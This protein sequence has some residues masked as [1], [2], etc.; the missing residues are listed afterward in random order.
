[1]SYCCY[2]T[3][4]TG[5][6]MPMFYIGHTTVAKITKGYRGS[7]SS[8]D[9][10]KVWKEEL[11]NN[12]HLFKTEI[13]SLHETRDEALLQEE[14]YHKKFKVHK[15]SLYINKATACGSFYSEAKGKKNPMYGSKRFGAKNP[16]Y[17][18]SHSKETRNKMSLS[19]K[20]KHSQPKTEE[21]KS[22]MR[23]KYTGKS[24]EQRYGAEKS[25]E[26]KNILSAPKSQ[27]HKNKQS[28]S[29]KNKPK[30]T[31]QHCGKLSSAGNYAKW[32]G[33]K[34]KSLLQEA[35]HP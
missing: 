18:K 3:T 11:K 6:K 34:C 13:L 19:G 27:E 22:L 17:G 2:L 15:S 24:F 28:E 23:E 32:H 20:G 9:Y 26:M 1:M 33:I 5:N 16:M 21:F 7:V 35:A 12:P 14:K 10:S 25:Q 4:Y 30:I 8:K 29:M 31:C